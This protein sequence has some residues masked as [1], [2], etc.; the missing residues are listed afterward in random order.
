LDELGKSIKGIDLSACLMEMTAHAYER[1]AA[2]GVLYRR[3]GDASDVLC[4]LWLSRVRQVAKWSIVSNGTPQCQ[5]LARDVLNILP[6]QFIEPDSIKQI[7]GFLAQ[8]GIVL[9]VEPTIKGMKMDGAVF[10]ATTGQV[11]I[12]LSLRYQRLDH[13]WF[14]LMHELAHVCLHLDRLD[15]PILDDFD[16]QD[17]SDVES[18]AN[19]LASIAMIPSA[20]WRSNPVK[21]NPREEV[22][23]EFAAKLGIAPQIVAGRFQRESNRY[24]IFSGIVNEVDVREIF[25]QHEK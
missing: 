16:V 1:P 25:W 22:V 23:R 15:S 10:R 5:G 7:P 2:A 18:E 6:R 19:R 3:R 9:I 12:G 14:S 17:D 11:V 24:D 8:F 13:F 4:D 20:A 21:F